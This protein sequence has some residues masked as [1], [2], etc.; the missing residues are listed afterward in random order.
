MRLLIE[1]AWVDLAVRHGA[2]NLI[3]AHCPHLKNGIKYF[4]PPQ[5][6]V[7]RIKLE[8]AFK[9]QHTVFCISSSE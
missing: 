6:N 5:R 3:L 9:T 1:M 4:V 8:H 7:I 2:R